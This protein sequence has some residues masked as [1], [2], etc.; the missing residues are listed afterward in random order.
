MTETVSRSAS[1]DGWN[2]PTKNLPPLDYLARSQEQC[3]R[4]SIGWHGP[5]TAAVAV[6]LI[7]H[8]RR[9]ADEFNGQAPWR[10]RVDEPIALSGLGSW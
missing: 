2:E 1:A 10:P 3:A 6:L 7:G 8:R 4:L 9:V 5:P